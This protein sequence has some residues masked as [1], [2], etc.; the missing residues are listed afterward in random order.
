ME[1]VKALG[2]T[3]TVQVIRNQII[4]YIATFTEGDIVVAEYL[5]L[6]MLSRVYYRTETSTPFG[7]YSLNIICPEKNA[8]EIE[9]LFQGI[10]NCVSNILPTCTT[11]N[12]SILD[13]RNADYF[14]QKVR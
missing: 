2:Y 12:L 9:R 4:S 6:C 5:L 14:P 1:K 13:L 11:L 10:H 3:D 8:A 7:H